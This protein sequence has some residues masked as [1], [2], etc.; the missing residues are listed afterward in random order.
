[1]CKTVDEA[2]DILENGPPISDACDE[3]HEEDL[4]A[5]ASEVLGDSG[6]PLE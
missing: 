6:E 5:E 1:M 2:L 4:H 3:G